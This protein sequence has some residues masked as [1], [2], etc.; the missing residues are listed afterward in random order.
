MELNEVRVLI[1]DG[2]NNLSS[3][4]A[5]YLK[6]SGF[7]PKVINNSY[8][9]QKTLL[10]WRPHFLFIDLL[11]PGCYAQEALKFI[12]ERNLAG[13]GGI[14]VIVMSKHNA[15][16]NVR[17][18]L[19][20]GAAD[21]IVKPLKMIDLLQRLALLT[22]A[23]RYNFSSIVNTNEQQI[24][25]YFQMISLLVEAANQGKEISPLR[26]ELS[27]MVSLALKAVRVSIIQTNKERNQ[28]EVI[29]SSDDESLTS[30][31]LD[32]NKY[33]E[34][35]YVLRTEKA[36]FIESLEKDKTMAFVKHEVKS[37]SFDSM[38]VLPLKRGADVVGCLS[39][40]MPK[41]CKQ[42]SFFDIKIAEIASQLIAMTWKFENI[43]IAKKA[44]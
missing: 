28:I 31:K 21:F 39:I 12:N 14:Q 34:V 6:E 9:M 2:D 40:R 32:L 35:Q 30:L 41:D 29:R 15:E 16:L 37:I 5:G 4:M 19:E 3:R 36:L 26:F 42:L 23:K 20:A 27:K 33:P 38:M 18:C 22:Q 24:K 7:T 17:N 11:F 1:A 44:A 10:E 25:N 8:L 43:K 13:D